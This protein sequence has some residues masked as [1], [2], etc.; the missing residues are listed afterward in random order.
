MDQPAIPTGEAL[1]LLDT[2]FAT[3]PLG[4]CFW[5]TE[6]RYQRINDALAR[7]NGLSVEEHLGRRIEDVLPVLGPELAQL[8]HRILETGDPVVDLEV[9]GETPAAPGVERIWLATYY[10]VSDETGRRLGIGA[11]VREVTDERRAKAETETVRRQT[12]FLARAG[13]RMTAS[14]DY[15][16]TLQGVARAAV[17]VVADWCGVTMLRPNG[18]LEPVAAAHSDPELEQLAWRLSE[19][20]PTPPDAP[21]GPANVIRTGEVE[22]TPEITDEMLV[23]GAQ[24]EEHLELLRTLNLRSA[25]VVPL[26]TPDRTLGA[27]TLV[28]SE[29]DRTFTRDVVALALAL[30]AR[31]ALAVENARLYSERSHIARTLQNSL[32][33]AQLP[34]I[35]GMEV[36]AR[37]RASGEQ[38][39]VGGD[40]YDLFSAD[41]GVWTALIGDVAGKGPEAAAVT[42]LTRH[43]LWTAALRDDSP[44]RNLELLNEALLTHSPGD[45][46]F[47]TVIYTRV[48]PLEEGG[49]E[50]TLSNGGHLP[51]VILRADGST[52]LVAA[53][54]TLVGAV[55]DPEFHEVSTRLDPGDLLLLYTDGV[56]EVSTTDVDLGE[57]LMLE[58]LR[59]SAGRPC[60]EVVEAVERAAVDAQ[61]GEPRDDIAL[62]AVRA[63]P[64]E[65]D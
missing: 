7:A 5:D 57:R 2:L 27:L 51:P 54:G 64:L 43:T 26:K 48:R 62:L 40:F 56:T 49:A 44:V 61:E 33:P 20:Y 55:P 45:W 19:Q 15:E 37:Y 17:P 34:E 28:F 13:A 1:A 60:A 21:T 22:H 4:L 18:Q 46:R 41:T 42:S 52:E 32:L 25:L 39:E 23:A 9:R 36:A 30:A 63:R 10:P 50:V 29:S 47:C 16:T 38:N 3:A 14:M 11:I 6:L 53:T 65:G 12:E 59:E 31:A 24:D 8:C 35:P 58:A